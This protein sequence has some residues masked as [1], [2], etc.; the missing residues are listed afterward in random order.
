MADDKAPGVETE[1]SIDN[2]NNDDENDESDAEKNKD[3]T[4]N[5]TLVRN[6]AGELVNAVSQTT[7]L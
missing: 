3:A 6:E 4:K 1:A 5:N 7:R 2:D